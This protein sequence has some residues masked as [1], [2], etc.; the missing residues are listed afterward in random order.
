MPNADRLGDPREGTAPEGEVEWWLRKAANANSD[1]QRDIINH[2]R[3]FLSRMAKKFRSHYYVSCWH[4]NQF[5]N[6]AM[7]NC[8][9]TQ[10]TAVA[11]RTTYSVLRECLPSYVEMGMVRYID[12]A[13]ERLPTMN[14]FEYITHKDVY[15]H[16]ERE[17]RAVAFPPVGDELRSAHF[18]ENYF[19]SESSAGFFLFAPPVVLTRLIHG[20]VLHPEAPQEFKVEISELCAKNALPQPEPSR[21]NRPPTYLA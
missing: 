19:E 17:V 3:I 8:Y 11:I 15:F 12:Y 6:N 10:P 18:R 9:T 14:M 1:E 5:E 21:K 13:T 16:F 7:W 20:V 2:N 4:M